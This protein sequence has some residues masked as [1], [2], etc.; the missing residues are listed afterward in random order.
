LQIFHRSRIVVGD[1]LKAF[2]LW[3]PKVFKYIKVRNHKGISAI[4]LSDFDRINIVFGM[5]NSG[6]TSIL[7]AIAGQETVAVGKTLDDTTILI[8]QFSLDAGKYFANIA[9]RATRTFTAYIQSLKESG[10]IWYYGEEDKIIDECA[11]TMSSSKELRNIDK[12]YDM[13]KILDAWFSD[14]AQAFRPFYVPPKRKLEVHTPINLLQN[15]ESF[16]GGVTN[17]LFYLKNQ[18][19]SSSE[20]ELFEQISRAFILMSDYEFDVV[21]D[22]NNMIRVAFR[23]LTEDNW[24]SAEDSG[25]GLSDLLILTTLALGT[26]HTVVCIEEPESHLHPETQKRFLTFLSK[27]TNKQFVLS[28]HSHVFLNPTLVDTIYYTRYSKN[29]IHVTNET[30]A[31][32][33][34]YN[35]GY[36]ISDHLTSDAIVLT[37]SPSDQPILEEVFRF[38]DLDSKFRINY[39]PLSDEVKTYLDM[40]IFVGQRNV[41]AL[42]NSRDG[43]EVSTDRFF[44]SC[45]RMGIGVHRLQRAAIENYFTIDALR[46]VYGDEIPGEVIRLQPDII[47]DAQVGFSLRRKS[48][49]TR[50]NMIVAAIDMRDIADTDLVTF[51]RV[52]KAALTE[53]DSDADAAVEADPGVA[54]SV[55][56]VDRESSASA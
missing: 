35:L 12:L 53:E 48:V 19:P 15:I 40:S 7:E 45:E 24:I 28:T 31:A 13:R 6:K 17:Y 29:A 8:D 42:T 55:I 23:R 37:E 14:V 49:K 27:I 46:A 4:E 44:G 18:Q 22:Q 1:S 33:S 11:R 56:S 34:L 38:V 3:T 10:A 41:F 30:E 5:N 2:A 43:N 51:C 20:S 16:G 32:I 39:F 25:L 21:P 52:V 50:N 36:S 47:V 54:G 9:K 26:S